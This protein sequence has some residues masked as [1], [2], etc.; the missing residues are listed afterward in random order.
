MNKVDYRKAAFNRLYGNVMEL[1]GAIY[2]AGYRDYYLKAI[3]GEYAPCFEKF[4]TWCDSRKE[5]EELIEYETSFLLEKDEEKEELS[6]LL[7]KPLRF[8]DYATMLVPQGGVLG[9]LDD[10]IGDYDEGRMFALT[11]SE[12]ETIMNLNTGT[13]MYY[14]GC[15]ATYYLECIFPDSYVAKL[16]AG[17]YRKPSDC[18]IYKQAEKAFRIIDVFNEIASRIATPNVGDAWLLGCKEGI[19]KPFYLYIGR[20]SNFGELLS[21]SRKRLY[22]SRINSIEKLLYVW[23]KIIREYNE[24]KPDEM[25]VTYPSKDELATCLVQETW[26]EPTK[27][28]IRKP[29]LKPGGFMFV[30]YKPYGKN[31]FVNY[32]GLLEGTRKPR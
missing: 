22:V 7:R 26:P 30:E 6:L 4:K 31:S 12:G 28:Q 23:G 18:I 17:T 29:E 32:R 25:K 3:R 11:N 1:V 21:Q 27:K 2:P 19:I 16:F 10:D 8:F 24:D 20:N 5:D 15:L 14:F 9:K 13:P